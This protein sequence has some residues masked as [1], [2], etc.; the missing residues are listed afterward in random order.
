[1]DCSTC[2]LSALALTRDRSLFSASSF[3]PVCRFL[4]T[5]CSAFPARFGLLLPWQCSLCASSRLLRLW[6]LTIR[7]GLRIAPYATTSRPRV[8]HGLLRAQHFKLRTEYRLLDVRRLTFHSDREL[9]RSLCF[10]SRVARGLLRVQHFR[11]LHRLRSTPASTLITPPR[12]SITRLTTLGFKFQLAD[13][14]ARLCYRPRIVGGS[15]RRQ[16]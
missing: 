6:R 7:D 3:R 15:L 9:L 14:A 13:I 1:M 12:L 11:V 4:H 8:V 16:Y 5:R 2:K 10:A